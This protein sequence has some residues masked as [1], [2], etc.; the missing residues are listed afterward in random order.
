M[1]QGKNQGG[2]WHLDR[3][4]TI[5]IILALLLNAGSSIWWASKL[6][7]TVQNHE[8]RITVN[9]A[10]LTQLRDHNGAL[11]ERLARIETYQQVQT[12]TLQEIKDE[13]KRQGGAR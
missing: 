1:A 9:A 5:G 12:E 13:L 3:K 2:D 6:D 11:Y 8:E 10:A 7:Y 4:V